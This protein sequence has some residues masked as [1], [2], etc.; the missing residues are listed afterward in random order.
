VSGPL[1]GIRV[2]D[3]TSVVSGPSATVMLA[4]QGA[5]VIKIESGDGDH[6]RSSAKGKEGFGAGFI[7][8]NRGKRSV[9]LDLKR[10]EGARILWQLIE[11]ADVFA[12]NMRPGVMERLGFA[13]PDVRVRNPGIIYLS[14]SGVGESGPYSHKRVYDPV[15]QSLSGLADIQSH[16]ETLRPRMTR[17]LIADKTTG[18][19]GAQAVTAA[20]FHRER[21]GE[22]QHV[23]VSM[24]DTMVS[25]LWPEGMSNYTIKGEGD[26]TPVTAPHDMIFEA[27]DGYLTVGTVSDKEWRCLCEAFDKPQWLSDPRFATPALRNQHRQERLT[28][29]AEVLRCKKRDEWIAIL[30]EADVPCAPVLRRKEILS[31]P[32]VINNELVQ[33][34][35][36]P[37]VGEV[38][39]ARPAARFE[40]SPAVI[41]GP[42]PALGQHTRDVLRELGYTE[43]QIHSWCEAKIVT[44]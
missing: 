37:T 31:H 44:G 39:Q 24:L 6:M 40:R 33:E 15:I 20:L 5:D 17:T 26:V 29:V 30:E 32:Q 10:T 42:A 23:R 7:S 27:S 38:R 8:C 43:R 11:G 22:G 4:D 18:V 13:E 36:H 12:Q 14:I 2:L 16:T 9:V 35:D 1:A 21:T 28:L 34:F 25:F 3:L 41:G 19:F